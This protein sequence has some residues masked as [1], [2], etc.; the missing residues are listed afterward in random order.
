MLEKIGDTGAMLAAFRQGLDHWKLFGPPRDLE[1]AAAL[2]L[3]EIRGLDDISEFNNDSTLP[4]AFICAEHITP[5]SEECTRQPP[6]AP[7]KIQKNRGTLLTDTRE[8]LLDSYDADDELVI[9]T[10]SEDNTAEAFQDRATD[11]TATC[12]ILQ[13]N[14]CNHNPCNQP[15]ELNER[16]SSPGPGPQQRRFKV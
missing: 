5:L 7:R 3:A 15:I 13:C 6:P 11:A 9:R 4:T 10:C 1:L 16:R 8:D 14:G 12:K 2:N